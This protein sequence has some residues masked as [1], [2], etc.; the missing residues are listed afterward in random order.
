MN[1]EFKTLLAKFGIDESDIQPA[2]KEISDKYYIPHIRECLLKYLP[3]FNEELNAQ[4]IIYLITDLHTIFQYAI[5]NCI[6]SG[7]V[8]DRIHATFELFTNMQ[9]FHSKQFDTTKQPFLMFQLALASVQ[10]EV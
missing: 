3:I 7:I 10:A 2:F 4:N 8:K 1:D 5:G 9:N 6:S